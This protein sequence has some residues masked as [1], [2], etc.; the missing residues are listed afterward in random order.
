MTI[1]QLKKEWRKHND[2]VEVFYDDPM[3]VAYGVPVNDFQEDF[4]RTERAILS[5]ILKK[6]EQDSEDQ[7]W[8]LDRMEKFFP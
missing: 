5:A 8:A 2:S 3:T 1:S 4:N 7:Q 6:A